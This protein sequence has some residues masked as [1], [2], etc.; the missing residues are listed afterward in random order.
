MRLFQPQWAYLEDFREAEQP[1]GLSVDSLP[2][3]L[4]A[5]PLLLHTATQLRPGFWVLLNPRVL[6]VL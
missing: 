1:S 5:W 4:Q 2:G 6:G 3:C